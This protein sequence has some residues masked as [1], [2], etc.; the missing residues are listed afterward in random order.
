V[1]VADKLSADIATLQGK[2]P[3]ITVDPTDLPL[4]A[5]EILED[6]LRDHLSGATDQGAGAAYPETLADVQGT[7]VVLGELAPLLDPRSPNLLGTATRQLDT[8]HQ[9]LLATQA[10]GQ[11]QSPSATPTAA[12]QRVDA[13]IGASLETLSLVPDLLEVPAHGQG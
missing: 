6:A 3:Q 5:H 8:L 2:L 12:R 7:Q 11:W 9:A 10:D 1:P 13:A 4:R